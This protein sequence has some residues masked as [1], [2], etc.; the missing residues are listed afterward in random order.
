MIRQIVLN[1][2]WKFPCPAPAGLRGGC[3]R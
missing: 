3:R 1:H 2:N